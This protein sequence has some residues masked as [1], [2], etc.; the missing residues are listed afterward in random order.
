MSILMDKILADKVK[1]RKKLADLPFDEKLTIM[2]RMRERNALLAENPLRNQQ[3]TVTPSVVVSGDAV[4]L[5][6]VDAHKTEWTLPV[7]HQRQDQSNIP[8]NSVTVIA[9]LSKQ[10]ERSRLTP[11]VESEPESGSR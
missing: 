8:Q 4:A 10:G 11:W 7:G 5:P 1:T 2:E 6:E 9:G 3:Y